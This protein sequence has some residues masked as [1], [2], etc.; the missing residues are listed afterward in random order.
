MQEHT[1]SVA[2]IELPLSLVQPVI[3]RVRRSSVL[4]AMV[5]SYYDWTQISG[6]DSYDDVPSESHVAIC[7]KAHLDSKDIR[8]Y[9]S[10]WATHSAVTS[11]ILRDCTLYYVDLILE[12]ME[13]LVIHRSHFD[14]IGPIR[15]MLRFECLELHTLSPEH[16]PTASDERCSCRTGV[17]LDTPTANLPDTLPSSI[18]PAIR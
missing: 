17:R 11:V 13:G 3:A 7:P 9:L 8:Q 10:V 14:L 5:P 12:D 15:D 1:Y 6:F 2:I 4:F 16:E 18:T